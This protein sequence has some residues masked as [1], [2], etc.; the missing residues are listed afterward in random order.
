MIGKLYAN[1]IWIWLQ[2]V[3][4]FGWPGGSAGSKMYCRM[5]DPD[6]SSTTGH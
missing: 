4:T 1:A 3:K 6:L 2:K 5:G